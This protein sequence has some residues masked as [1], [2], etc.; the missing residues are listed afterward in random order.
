M[1]KKN[2]MNFLLVI[3]IAILVAII[4][5]ILSVY[6]PFSIFYEWTERN[7]LKYM[8]YGLVAGVIALCLGVYHHIGK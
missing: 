1:S 4:M 8:W 7:H 3:V 2:G 5:T 6:P